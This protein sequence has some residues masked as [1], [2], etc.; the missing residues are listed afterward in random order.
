[1][2]TSALVVSLLCVMFSSCVN[3]WHFHMQQDL[4]CH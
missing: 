4:R 2:H 1:M 3:I